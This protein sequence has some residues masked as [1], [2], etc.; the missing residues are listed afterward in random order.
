MLLRGYPIVN[1]VY[2]KCL[3]LVPQNYEHRRGHNR[4]HTKEH[5]PK[6]HPNLICPTGFGEI[7]HPFDAV[8]VASFEHPQKANNQARG[9]EH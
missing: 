4:L 9:G 2:I 7:A 1:P 6:T 3:V 5:S 8:I